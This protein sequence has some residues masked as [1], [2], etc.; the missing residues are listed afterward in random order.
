[1]SSALRVYGRL[2]RDARRFTQPDG[3]AVVD[4]L[5]RTGPRSVDVTAR[6]V[7]GIGAGAQYIAARSAAQLRAGARVTVHAQDFA[8]RPYVEQLEL[9]GVDLIENH[10]AP[11][12]AVAQPEA[13][14]A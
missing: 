10:D 6:R 8:F 11:A 4:V 14:Q 12:A 13:A 7:I 5:L 9:R 1:M 2:A 3:T